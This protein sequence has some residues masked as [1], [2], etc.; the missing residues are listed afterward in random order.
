[1]PLYRKNTEIP[2]NFSEIYENATGGACGPLAV[3]VGAVKFSG[4]ISGH[5]MVDSGRSEDE[6]SDGGGFDGL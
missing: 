5:K 6:D 2:L 4:E 1:V 3:T